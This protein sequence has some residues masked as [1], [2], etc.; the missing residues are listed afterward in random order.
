MFRSILI[1]NRGE[2]AVRILRTCREMGIRAVVAYSTADR[3][4]LAVRLADDAVCVGPPQ[5]GRS[6]LSIPSLLYGA[7]R[8]KAEAVHP[9]FGFLAE[10]SEFATAC[11]DAGLAFIGPAPEHLTLMGDKQ[12]AR[13]AMRKAGLPVLPGSPDPL[14]GEDDAA[15]Q[16]EKIG[17]PVVLKAL[18]G[19]G[20]RGIVPVHDPADLA[21]A[22]EAARS[23]ALALFHDERVYVEKFVRDGRH[24]EVQV[25]ADSHGNVIHLGERDCSV[26]RRHQKIIEESPAPDLPD[27]VRHALWEAAVTG[28]RAIGLR[29][30][31]T[32]EF[33]VDGDRN[34]H[35]IEMNARLQVE[36]PVTEARTGIDIVETMIREAAGEPLALDQRD[37]RLDGHAIEARVNAE[38]P[39]RDWAGSAGD[40]GYLALPGGPGIRVDT[41][42]VPDAVVPPH[43]DSLL[44]KIIAWAPTRDRAIRRLDRAL[45]E[46]RCDGLTTNTAFLRRVLAD[47]AFRSG[48]HR[49]GLIESLREPP[50]V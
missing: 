28:A 25:I 38:D 11:R 50:G 43:Y 33:L 17:Y 48:T 22:F 10:E 20:G 1:A 45:G 49:L 21:E 16:A 32:F 44:A 2:V 30:V 13:A 4:S 35:F 5:A 47:P 12:A 40:V 41:Y 39:D 23:T 24:I 19:G 27:D 42:L 31:G 9:G 3:D 14:T 7:A 8:T 34:A 36:H 29:N 46:F 18:A 26:Q 37:V 15:A 6:Y